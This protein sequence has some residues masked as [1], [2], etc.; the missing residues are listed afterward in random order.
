MSV[1]AELTIEGQFA[2]SELLTE[3]PDVPVQLERVVPAGER[4]LPLIWIH[5]DDPDPIEARLREHRLIETLTRL[6][7]FEDRALYRIEW[8]EEPDSVFDALSSQ[9]ADLLDAVGVGDVW[10][11]ELRFPTHE[12]LS[13]FRS[14]CDDV[15]L[16]VSLRRV[17][18][19]DEPDPTI[20]YGLTSR[21]YETL[22]RAVE[23]GYFDIPRQ[24]PAKALGAECSFN[25]DLASSS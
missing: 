1:I 23:V 21:Q 3:L 18:R 15:G 13:D 2:L 12:A 22:V 24:M 8:T 4:T 25:Y 14:H 7:T 10:Q 16:P 20:Q 9:Q 11:F 19:P 5:T 17:Y 6:D